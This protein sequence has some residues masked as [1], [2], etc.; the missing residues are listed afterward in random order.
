MTKYTHPLENTTT[1]TED[2]SCVQ[3]LHVPYR[4]PRNTQSSLSAVANVEKTCL[5]VLWDSVWNTEDSN[6]VEIRCTT[7][8]LIAVFK[9]FK[10]T[11]ETFMKYF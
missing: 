2:F 5:C 9:H 1:S 6:T 8:L 7:K 4:I 10:T 11:C 3:I